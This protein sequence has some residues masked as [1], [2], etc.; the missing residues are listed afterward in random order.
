MPEPFR[1]YHIAP[2]PPPPDG[3][4][5]PQRR[6]ASAGDLFKAYLERLVKLIPA[7]I[8]GLYMALEGIFGGRMP[9]Q[10]RDDAVPKPT[11]TDW[12]NCWILFGCSLACLVF[13]IFF[14][15]KLSAGDDK[16]PQS[17][18]VWWPA[19]AFVL[20]LL[21]ISKPFAPL[22]VKLR[23]DI[24]QDVWPRITAALIVL[25]TFIVPL[26]ARGDPLPAP[27]GGSRGQ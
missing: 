4:P 27:G 23:P 5:V 22:L 18:L 9:L 15:R 6:E 17:A 1:L 25:F 20:W 24:L 26:V 16:S 21:Y 14:R 11:D 8:L 13:L 2:P 10:L 12:V 19:L 3:P 7:E